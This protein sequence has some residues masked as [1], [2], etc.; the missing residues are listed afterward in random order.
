M[1]KGFVRRRLWG[2]GGEGRRPRCQVVDERLAIAS[3]RL[4]AADRIDEDAQVR[5]AEI[6]QEAREQVDDLGVAARAL[7]AED[8]GSELVELPV[9]AA[10]RLL[11]AKHRPGVPPARQ[12]LLGA[13]VVLHVRSRG[14]GRPLRPQ[15]EE[16]AVMVDGVHLLFDDVRRF[17]DRADEESRRL[18]ARRADLAEAVQA[19]RARERPLDA[20][21]ATDLVREDV[22]HSFDGA[23]LGHGSQT[24]RIGR[25]G[26]LMTPGAAPGQALVAR[27]ERGRRIG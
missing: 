11:G 5:D 13:D 6:S 2:I 19:H 24:R 12:R 21:P 8:L 22:V 16:L 7:V 27:L 25:R 18:D 14:P 17:A 23:D 1:R 4:V 3:A 26:Q 9:P 10:L 20:V 15:G